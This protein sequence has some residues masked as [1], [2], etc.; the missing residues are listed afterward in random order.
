MKYLIVLAVLL[1]MPV[2]AEAALRFTPPR[3]DTSLQDF[4]DKLGNTPE[5]RQQLG[6]AF[7]TVKR[8]LFE[9]PNASRGWK[10]NIAGAY[11]FFVSSISTVW[12]GEAPD[13]AA[14]DQLFAKLGTALAPDLA[15]VSDREKAELYST[16]IGGASLPLLLFIDGS[17]KKNP[18]QIEQARALAA[19]YSRELMKMEPDDVRKLLQSASASGAVAATTAPTVVSGASGV[20]G[21]YECQMAQLSHGAGANF[22]F[23]YQPTGM[24]FAIQGGR[25][26]SSS[27]GG[28]VQAGGDVVS[29]HGGSYDGW[30]GAR[31]GNAIVFRKNQGDPAPGESIRVGDLR[32]GRRS[33]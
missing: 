7:A 5:E 29:F 28:T 12:T 24:W 20:D 4:A 31:R 33:G 23:Q 3:G 19:Q 17:E 22:S 6:E 11:T 13:P 8:E 26:T 18:A 2:A 30:R 15:G 21:R 27:A 1:C 16:L 14:Q 10:N 9:Q 25:Y 32:C